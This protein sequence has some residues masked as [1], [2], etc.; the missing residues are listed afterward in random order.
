M[1]ARAHTHTHMY[2]HI[3]IYIYTHTGHRRQYD[4]AH[5]LWMLDNRGYRHTLRICNTAFPQQQWL[6]KRTSMLCY[7]CTAC[8][9]CSFRDMIYSGSVTYLVVNAASYF[10]RL[11]SIKSIYVLQNGGYFVMSDF[12]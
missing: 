3:Y 8:L 7:T 9:V 12:P 11:T 6:R 4:T 2:I 5:A 10:C 1:H